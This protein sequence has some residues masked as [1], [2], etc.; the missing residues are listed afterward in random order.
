M[1]ASRL[2]LRVCSG[3]AV[4]D[5]SDATEMA[6]I[7]TLSR[8]VLLRDAAENRRPQEAAVQILA[9]E[10]TCAVLDPRRALAG[11]ILLLFHADHERTVI[12]ARLDLC[13][14]GKDGQGA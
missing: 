10:P 14:C 11:D 4:I 3:I 2:R 8:L 6:S 12:S 13:G 1:P 7:K 9:G 5:L